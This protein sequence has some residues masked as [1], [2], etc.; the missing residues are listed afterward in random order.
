MESSLYI[1]VL[2]DE[3]IDL[4]LQQAISNPMRQDDLPHMNVLLIQ[5]VVQL[6]ALQLVGPLLSFLDELVTLLHIPDLA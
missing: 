3:A 5:R 1:G 6:N 4:A 2:F